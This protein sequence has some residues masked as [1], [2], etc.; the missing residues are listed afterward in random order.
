MVTT[1]VIKKE[2]SSKTYF[3]EIPVHSVFSFGYDTNGEYNPAIKL[4]ATAYIYVNSKTSDISFSYVPNARS[5]E[6][7]LV[8]DVV[9]LRWSN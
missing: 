2:I 3:S 4:N 8:S 5:T 6:V 7:I 1:T 9:E